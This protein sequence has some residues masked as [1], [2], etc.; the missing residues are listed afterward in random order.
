[1][2]KGRKA[3]SPANDADLVAMKKR[4]THA[5]AAIGSTAISPTSTTAL[6]PPATSEK[7]KPTPVPRKS[8][9]K[10][11]D[12][13][14]PVRPLSNVKLDGQIRVSKEF[15]A[16]VRKYCLAKGVSIERVI[17]AVVK[18]AKDL[19]S[20]DHV[21]TLSLV[22][23]QAT[24]NFDASPSVSWKRYNYSVSPEVLERSFKLCGDTF[25]QSPA[26]AYSAAL[27]AS[28]VHAFKAITSR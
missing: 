23:K 16:Q 22:S 4:L 24:A 7:T 21:L 14:T 19:L 8:S 18:E 13:E 3:V 27:S 11:T 26:S 17:T 5:S 28:V 10:K 9:P 1:M 25:R 2:A 12:T 6:A 20:G 15:D